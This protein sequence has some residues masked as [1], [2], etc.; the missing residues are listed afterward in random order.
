MLALQPLETVL[1]LLWLT[2][3]LAALTALI[4]GGSRVRGLVVLGVAI[5]VPVLGS[6]VAIGY[7]A[8]LRS[9]G[10]EATRS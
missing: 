8:T 9:R 10:Q 2:G 3:V 7:L 4:R 6:A 5:V 1:L